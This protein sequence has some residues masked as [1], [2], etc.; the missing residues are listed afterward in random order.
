MQLTDPIHFA[1]AL[2][3]DLLDQVSVDIGQTIVAAL[4]SE[5]QAGVIESEQM[6]DR[7]VEVVDMDWVLDSVE[8][9]VIGFAVD[10]AFF[11]S[12]AGHPN[13]EGSVVVVSTIIATLDH[14]RASEFASPDHEGV[15]EQ[16]ESFEILDQGRTWPVGRC[17]IVLYAVGQIAVLVP[18]LMEQL[19]EANAPL[20]QSSSEQAV[21]CKACFLRILDPIEVESFFA[22][23]GKVHQLGCT[24]LQF[25]RQFIALDTGCDFRVADLVEAQAVEIGDR[26]DRIALGLDIDPFGV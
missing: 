16:S 11:Q 23:G 15:F 18:D 8:P 19:H 1:N 5:G 22:L 17:G 24:G 9:K 20:K 2:G 14:R 26:V 6:Q 13:A 21:P 12:T 4:E 25:R 3:E 7:G 10:P